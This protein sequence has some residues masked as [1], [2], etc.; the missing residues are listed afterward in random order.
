MEDVKKLKE[1][2]KPLILHHWDTDGICSVAIIRR[3]LEGVPAKTMVPRIGMYSLSENELRDIERGGHDVIIVA[4][5]AM[6]ER[7]YDRLVSLDAEIWIFDHHLKERREDLHQFNPVARGSPSEDY[8][9]TTWVLHEYL[10]TPLD[11]LTTLG[12]IGDKEEKIRQSPQYASIKEYMESAS[13]G[14]EELL[15]ICALIDSSYRVGDVPAIEKAVSFLMEHEDD[16][17]AL[18]TNE[19]WM[20]NHERVSKR[21]AAEERAAGSPAEGILVHR[22]SSDFDIVSAVSRRL[23]GMN[24]VRISI[25]VQT[26]FFAEYDR[27]YVRTSDFSLD[28]GPILDMAVGRGHISGG[29]REVV[30]TVVPVENTEE[31]L[32]ETLRLLEAT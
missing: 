13:L 4:D 28:L 10:K 9:S 8:P 21:I 15:R 11:L 18:L 26:G 23:S 14:L 20:K 25:V 2:K 31:F 32:K 27:V 6:P 17:R 24:G 1:A 12:A 30:G 5:L 3:F 7:A 19:T 16:P 29:K 22:F